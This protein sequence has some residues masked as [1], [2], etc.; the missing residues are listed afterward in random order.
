MSNT[1][2]KTQF[3]IGDII[4]YESSPNR[5]IVVGE[6]D[7]YLHTFIFESENYYSILKDDK[8]L[9]GLIRKTIPAIRKPTI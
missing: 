8:N 6:D 7:E 2:N 4:G 3:F 1:A 9:S 5:L